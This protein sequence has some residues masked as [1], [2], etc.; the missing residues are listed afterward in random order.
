MAFSLS[1]AG[2]CQS[3]GSKE[4]RRIGKTSLLKILQVESL[5]E[6]IYA[7]GSTRDAQETYCVYLDLQMIK[8]NHTPQ[9]FWQQI[10]RRLS[11]CVDD[12]DLKAKE[13]RLFEVLCGLF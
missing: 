13:Y 5:G 10:L 2:R 4:E 7:E 12:D 6:G 8:Y 9:D 1:Y 3:R 11:R